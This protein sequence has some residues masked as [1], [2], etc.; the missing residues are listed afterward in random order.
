MDSGIVSIWN[1]SS[2]LGLLLQAVLMLGLSP[3]VNMILKKWKAHF[4]GRQGPSLLQGYFDLFKYFR[5]ETVVSHQTSWLF[6]ATP[7]L[8]FA[9]TVTASM[10]MPSLLIMHP[11]PIIGGIIVLVYLLGLARFFLISAAME[12]GSGFCGM[13]SSRETM[14]S[15]LIEPVL[16]LT[17]FVISLIGQ[18]TNLFDIQTMLGNRGIGVYTPAYVLAIVALFVTVLAE[19]GRVP[20]DNPETHYELTM[21]HE[22]M[23]LD[24]SGKPLGLLLWAA[25]TKQLLMLTLVANCIIPWGLATNWVALP[26]AA[27]I[28]LGKLLLVCFC[29]VL[30]ETTVAKMRLFRVKDSL[31]ASF[32]IALIALVF[33]SQYHHGGFKP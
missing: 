26:L 5:K 15:C 24:Y 4:Q 25:W 29:V 21:I 32:I 30:V 28:Y 10:L 7:L 8:V 27:L 1:P 19:T 9:C 2:V 18:S 3:L 6:L 33:A 20:F 16:L 31:G 23:L 14:F 11:V 22:G 13:A 12:P 17:L